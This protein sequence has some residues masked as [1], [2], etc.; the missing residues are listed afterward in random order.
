MA[1]ALIMLGPLILPGV[2]G[3]EFVLTARLTDWLVPQL[4]EE[5]TVTFPDEEPQVT[6]IELVPPPAVIVASPGMFQLYEVALFAV[7]TE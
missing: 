5:L 3:T 7:L 2:E 6:V 1:F 4:F